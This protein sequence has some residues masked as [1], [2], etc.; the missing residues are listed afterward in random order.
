MRRL[1][2]LSLAALVA[3]CAALDSHASLAQVRTPLA[4]ISSGGPSVAQVVA[5]VQAF[6]TRSATFKS[7]F[8]QRFWVKESK[9]ELR[10]HGHVTFAKPG[11]MDWLYDDPKDD[12]VL[13]DGNVMKL[14]NA[15]AKEMFEEPIDMSPF[16]AALSFLVDAGTFSARFSFQ[17]FLGVQTTFVGGYLLVGIPKQATPAYTKILFYVDI[18]SQVRRVVLIDGHGNRNRFDF[19]NPQVNQ[20]VAPMQF[21]FTPPP[22]T[23]VVR[24]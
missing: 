22:G 19:V 9:R 4:P 17:L 2:P 14:Y 10:S 1:R 18:S 11:M 20:Q 21:T 3:C 23:S 13:S 16:P 12:R 5:Q 6:Y 15:A 24:L 8:Q 7:E